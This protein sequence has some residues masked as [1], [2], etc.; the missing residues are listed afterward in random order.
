M[1]MTTPRFLI[2]LLLCAASADGAELRLSAIFQD[3]MVLQREK[4]I[5]IWGWAD[6]GDKIT[7]AFAGQTKAAEAGKHGKWMVTLAPLKASAK[8]RKLR[9]STIDAQHATRDIIIRDVLVGEV[10]VCSGQSNMSYCVMRFRNCAEDIPKMN[11]PLIRHFKVS[12]V[13]CT[14]PQEDVTG[15]WAVCSPDT[16]ARFSATAFYFGLELHMALSVPIGLINSSVGGTTIEQWTDAATLEANP[17]NAPYVEKRKAAI[18]AANPELLKVYQ[19]SAR[20]YL[21]LVGVNPSVVID[22]REDAL[23]SPD[24]SDAAWRPT[25]LPRKCA[26]GVT[27]FA[28]EVELPKDMIGKEL[29]LNLGTVNKEE[30]TYWNG[31]RIG[32][33]FFYRDGSV[34]KIPAALTKGAKNVLTVRC[35]AYRGGGISGGQSLSAADGRSISLPDDGWEF[36]VYAVEPVFP[37]ELSKGA[38]SGLY[39]GMIHP[40]IPYTIRGVVWYQGEYNTARA[41]EYR[42][43][44]PEMIQAWRKNWGEE[45]DFPFYYFQLANFKAKQS[46]PAETRPEHNWPALREAQ[47]IALSLPNTGMA[48]L[49]D[50][51][52][53][54][55][56]PRNI[57]PSN[58]QDQGKRLALIARDKVYGEN[59]VSSGPMY[60]SMTITGNR[61]IVRFKSVGSGLMKAEPRSRYDHTII[62][63]PE[64]PKGTGIL[65]FTIAGADGHFVFAKATITGKD[66]VTVWSERI[67]KPLHIRFAWHANP[68]HNLYNIEGLPAPPFRTD[69]IDLSAIDAK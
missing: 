41:Y 65:G 45:E 37:R 9:V 69:D 50:I 40:L 48:C 49:I 35:T 36:R 17:D 53:L 54:G 43:Q 46:A 15:A 12:H 13:D 64:H 59:I 26:S 20:D 19:K 34:H 33:Q 52:E 21:S 68:H 30:I 60:D 7:V 39:N 28:R 32:S 42:K 1:K 10:W 31:T 11:Y 63:T 3:H 56:N 2:A 18:E 58:N 51:G 44:F 57:H 55:V 61:I 24:L 67:Q 38:G 5:K 62:P 66:T 23:L 27:W 8:G 47:M 29:T 4:P 14:T 6:A 22:G 25:T 16:V